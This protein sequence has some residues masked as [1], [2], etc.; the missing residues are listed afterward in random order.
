MQTWAATVAPFM[1]SS[2]QVASCQWMT[3]SD[4]RFLVRPNC[5]RTGF[6]GGLNGIDSTVPRRCREMELFDGR[7]IDVRGVS[8]QSS[9]LPAFQSRRRRKRRIKS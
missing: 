5:D 1:P 3:E 7:G 6:Q 2:E 9:A 8:S 4:L